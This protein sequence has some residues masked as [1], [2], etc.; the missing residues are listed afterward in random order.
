MSD[1]FVTLA[2]APPGEARWLSRACEHRGGS[3][4]PGSGRE[5][6]AVERIQTMAQGRA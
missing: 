6:L 3:E 2:G 4:P 1:P 5:L